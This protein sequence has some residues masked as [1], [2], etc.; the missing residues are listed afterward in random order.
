MWRQERQ[1]NL[2]TR[3]VWQHE[4]VATAWNCPNVSIGQKSKTEE[5]SRQWRDGSAHG[6]IGFVSDVVDHDSHSAVDLVLVTV[7]TE[8]K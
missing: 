2:V 5:Y 1:G 6:H 7:M 4:Y 3:E 8:R